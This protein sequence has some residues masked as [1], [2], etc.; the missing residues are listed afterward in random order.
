MERGKYTSSIPKKNTEPF[1]NELR[2]V[3]WDEITSD[4]NCEQA[5]DNLMATIKR[6]T[7]KYT[8]TVQCKH[9]VKQE[10]PWL[11]DTLWNL[12]KKR[13]SALKKFLKSGLSTDRL[14]FKSLRNK[15]TMQLQ[16]AKAN[17][18]LEIIK[19][20]KG[21]IKSFGKVLTN[22]QERNVQRVKSCS[23]N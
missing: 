2:H 7:L 17:F 8:T 14:I 20:A 10:L 11:H 15:V 18:F 22:S 13:D 21:T 1:E 16:K 3:N 4:I 23:L 12:K 6:I 5:C 9:K 19:D